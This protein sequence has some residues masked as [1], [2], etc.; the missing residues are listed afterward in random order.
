MLLDDL[1]KFCERED[2]RLR[3]ITTTYCGATEAK[4]VQKLAELPHTEI[5]ISYHT[6]IERLHAKAYILCVI[7]GCIQPILVR[8]IFRNRPRPMGWNGICV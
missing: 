4:A 6:E 8:P 5:H 7:R 1:R 3:I 2:T